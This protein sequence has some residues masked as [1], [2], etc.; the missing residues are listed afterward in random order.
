MAG[1][2][3]SPLPQS[4]YGEA[5]AA[6][7]FILTSHGTDILGGPPI[8]NVVRLLA[9]MRTDAEWLAGWRDPKKIAAALDRE[10]IVVIAKIRACK[11]CRRDMAKVGELETL[12]R[13]ARQAPVPK[14][15]QFKGKKI[16][17]SRKVR[18]TARRLHQKDRKRA[19]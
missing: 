8:A 7:Q 9:Q 14:R 13:Q 16:R 15:R 18:A 5:R 2:S 12:A 4:Y 11:G 3:R 6:A 1:W 10:L 17:K 19:A